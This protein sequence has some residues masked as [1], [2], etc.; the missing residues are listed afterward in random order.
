MAYDSFT[1]LCSHFDGADQATA[2]T[3]PITSVAWTFGGTAQ[4]DTAR[5][6]FGSAS[7]LLDGDSDY[8]TH[9]DSDSWNLGAG[10]FTIDFWFMASALPT[11]GNLAGLLQQLVSVSPLDFLSIDI[12]NTSGTYSIRCRLYDNDTPIWNLSKNTSPNLAVD[13]WYHLAIVR[14]VNTVTAYQNGVSLGTATASGSSPD[15]A[16]TLDLGRFAAANFFAGWIDEVRVSKGI[17][18]WTSNFTPPAHAYGYGAQKI[19]I[20]E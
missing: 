7:L 20:I 5:R 8:I 10:D 14:C 15:F 18:R 6:K 4:L 9:D 3:D 2:Y 1:K 12:L 17:A 16:A 19:V 13:T 11:D